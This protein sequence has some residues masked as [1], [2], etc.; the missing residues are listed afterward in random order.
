MAA[1]IRARARSL[2]ALLR[3]AENFQS[4]SV[5]GSTRAMSALTKYVDESA[6]GAPAKR[7]GSHT[8]PAPPLVKSILDG[9][10]ADTMYV[11]GPG[12]TLVGEDYN[13]NR[14]VERPDG[15]AG[16]SRWV[17]YSGAAH[18]YENQ[19]P[20]SV[21]PEWHQWLHYISDE[22]PVNSPG[23]K[24]PAFVTAT[25]GH[26]SYEKRAGVEKYQPKGAWAWNAKG[27]RRNWRKF[28]AWK[29]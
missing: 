24:K 7:K 20:T 16:R 23:E 17:V 27:G 13:G 14:Y 11:H 22:N 1:T 26:P 2:S 28:E 19:N 8:S 15:Q 4:T 10:I 18:H 9:K 6:I 12:G 5:S 3:A 25:V 29:P 21:P